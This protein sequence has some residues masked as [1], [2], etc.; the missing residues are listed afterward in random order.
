MADTHIE[1][2][3][4]PIQTPQQLIVVV[5]L[6]FLVPIFLIVM[7]TQLITGGMKIEPGTAVMS[8]EA[9]A[10][11]LQPVGKVVFGEAPAAPAAAVA[12]A[13]G[14]TPAPAAASGKA[15]GASVYQS[16]CAMCHGA[17][18]LGAPKP[19]DKAAWKPRIAQGV[20]TLHEHA[21]KGIRSMPAKGGNAALPDTDVFAAVDYMVN[22]SK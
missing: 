7:L 5:V 12:S 21:I 6:S 9:I 20:A 3:S 8:D 10:K 4:T 14:G 15:D 1:E 2:H 17:G 13:G 22:Q 11:R 18:L 19:G 16:V